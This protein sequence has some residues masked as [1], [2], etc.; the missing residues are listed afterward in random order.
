[1]ATLA[2][3]DRTGAEVGKYEIDPTQI[4]PRIS[5]QLIHD[6]GSDATVSTVLVAAGGAALVAS[7]ILFLTTP[8]EQ[9]QATAR[10][11]P[12][13]HDRG[14]GLAIIGRF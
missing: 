7:A 1:M 12:I 2:I 4:A 11:T 9:E 14:T 6:A 8:R 10:I 3:H 5:K 13:I